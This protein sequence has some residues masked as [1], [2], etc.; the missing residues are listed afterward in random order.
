[1]KQNPL[2]LVIVKKKK[3]FVVGSFGKEKKYMIGDN[4][5]NRWSSYKTKQKKKKIKYEHDHNN[6][7]KDEHDDD[8]DDGFA[9]EDLF[10]LLLFKNICFIFILFF[11][12][13]HH[14]FF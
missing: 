8:D 3:G 11:S 13:S 1:M 4:K 7:N 2:P 6:N 9:D 12:R 14:L 10:L 5:R